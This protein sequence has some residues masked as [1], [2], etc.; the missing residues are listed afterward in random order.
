M[1]FKGR[2][3]FETGRQSAKSGEEWAEIVSP[4]GARTE[5]DVWRDVCLVAGELHAVMQ[6]EEHRVAELVVATV[7]GWQLDLVEARV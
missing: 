2:K 1:E 7:S 6:S 4:H 3:V 5:V